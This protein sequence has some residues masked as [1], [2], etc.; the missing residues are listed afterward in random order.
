MAYIQG[1]I[2]INELQAECFNVGPTEPTE[3]SE[4][5]F[6]VFRPEGHINALTTKNKNVVNLSQHKLS[7]MEINLINRSLTLI[8]VPIIDIILI[9]NSA[10]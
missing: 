6:K 2:P 4:G 7:G 9:M 5:T 3:L 1:A 10:D 8:P